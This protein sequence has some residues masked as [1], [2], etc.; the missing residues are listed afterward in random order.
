M[1]TRKELK[2]ANIVKCYLND[3]EMQKLTELRLQLGLTM[4]DLLRSR[5]LDPRLLNI[6]PSKLMLLLNEIGLDIT[7]INSQLKKYF[8]D[9]SAQRENDSSCAIKEIIE[10]Y[11]SHQQRLELQ[12][13][14]LLIRIE[15]RK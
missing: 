3:K 14:R 10:R 7:S 2:R 11:L 15:Q 13:R 1:K 4:S 5:L 12:I 9:S 6:N 8:E